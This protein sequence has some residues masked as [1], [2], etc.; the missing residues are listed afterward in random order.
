MLY[1]A[2]GKAAATCWLC[3]QKTLPIPTRL[4]PIYRKRIWV[5]FLYQWNGHV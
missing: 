3:R 5:G 1:P 4:W 2:L